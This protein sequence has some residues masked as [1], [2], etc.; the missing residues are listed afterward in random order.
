ML[1]FSTQK[2]MKCLLMLIKRS[3]HIIHGCITNRP[4]PYKDK[5]QEQPD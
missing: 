2:T 1:K 5:Y 3:Y 4:E